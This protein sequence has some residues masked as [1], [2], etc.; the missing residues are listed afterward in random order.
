MRVQ[1]KWVCGWEAV[2]RA[3]GNEGGWERDNCNS[4]IK[5]YI[6]KRERKGFV[7]DISL[8]QLAAPLI[9]LRMELL[10]ILSYLLR[11]TIEL[12]TPKVNVSFNTCIS[13]TVEALRK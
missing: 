8:V 13:P 10:W 9:A 1:K 11:K 4:I 12:L 5:K 2:C 7:G 3:E 6:S